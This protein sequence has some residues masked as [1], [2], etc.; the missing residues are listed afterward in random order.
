MS[1]TGRSIL[2]A[3]AILVVTGAVLADRAAPDSCTVGVERA[4]GSVTIPRPYGVDP[5]RRR[6]WRMPSAGSTP[7]AV[8]LPQLHS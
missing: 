6:A 4:R 3:A 7:G 2:V 1:L 8:L 5:A